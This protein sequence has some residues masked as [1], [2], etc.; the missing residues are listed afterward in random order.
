MDSSPRTAF[1]VGASAGIGRA[2][3]LEL[4]DRG[5]HVAAGAR[6]E[7]PLQELAAARPDA[8]RRFHAQT[9]DVTDRDGFGEAY[10]AVERAI[11]PVDTLIVNAGDYEPMPLADFDPELFR[12]LMEV[13]F[14]GAVNALA[15][16]LPAMLARGRGQILLTAS[17]SAYRGLPRAAPYGA[18]KAA[19]LNMAESL[20]PELA[21]RGVRLRVINPGFV[22]SRLTDKNDFSMPDI[23]SPE[24]AAAYIARRLGGRGFEI[25]FP[26]RFALALKTLRLLPYRLYFAAIRRMVGG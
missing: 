16:A 22:R 7:Q 26:P 13:N 3:A 23:V 5:W 9:L 15:A 6:R 20:H 2:L 24:Y 21:R 4:L 10:Q 1:L 11:G 8:G 19:L 18:S 12:R 25:A 14:Q 17:L